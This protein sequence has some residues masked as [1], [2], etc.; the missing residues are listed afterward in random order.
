MTGPGFDLG[1][2]EKCT[3]TNIFAKLQKQNVLK[4]PNEKHQ[5]L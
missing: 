2:L 1:S 3:S 5:Q 4:F